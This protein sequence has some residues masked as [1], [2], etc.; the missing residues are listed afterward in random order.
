MGNLRE[1][2]AAVEKRGAQKLSRASVLL[3]LPIFEGEYAARFGVLNGDRI[4]EMISASSGDVSSDDHLLIAAEFIADACRQVYARPEAGS[5][6]EPLTHEDGD[7]VRF[8]IGFAEV[9]ELG[10]LREQSGAAVVVAMWTNDEGTVSD[11]MLHRFGARLLDFMQDTT[12]EIAGELA[13]ES[14]GG[15]Q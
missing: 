15:P 8:D 4:Q 14:V 5:K 7:R 3:P 12:A 10:E 9:L 6:Y 13:G 2:H 11:V 1:V